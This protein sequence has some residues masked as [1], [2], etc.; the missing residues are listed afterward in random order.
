[1]AGLFYSRFTRARELA[2]LAG[3]ARVYKGLAGFAAPLP[4]ASP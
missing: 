3:L 2:E 1:M 4:A